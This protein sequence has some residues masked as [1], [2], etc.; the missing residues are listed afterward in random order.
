MSWNLHIARVV[1]SAKP[2]K[3]PL[4]LRPILT[5]CHCVH[6]AMIDSSEKTQPNGMAK[7]LISSFTSSW[8]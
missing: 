2:K 6:V 4:D 5:R 1:D 8:T 7:V 3:L